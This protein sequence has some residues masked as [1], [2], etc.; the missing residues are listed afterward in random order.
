MFRAPP[1]VTPSISPG[2]ED[3]FRDGWMTE[4]GKKLGWKIH[5]SRSCGKKRTRFPRVFATNILSVFG[6]G[7]IHVSTYVQHEL[8]VIKMYA[9]SQEKRLIDMAP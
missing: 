8:N 7:I 9:N 5:G 1:E 2:M 3:F 6:I 4:G